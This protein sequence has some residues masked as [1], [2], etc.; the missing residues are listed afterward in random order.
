MTTPEHQLLKTLSPSPLTQRVCFTLT[1]NIRR[2]Q[3]KGK[4]TTNLGWQGNVFVSLVL[5]WSHLLTCKKKT[6]LRSLFCSLLYSLLLSAFLKL[7]IK[8]ICAWGICIFFQE[9]DNIWN[10]SPNIKNES[11]AVYQTMQLVWINIYFFVLCWGF[12]SCL[13][14]FRMTREK[15]PF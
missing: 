14:V 5:K 3:S 2:F 6:H 12:D 15:V 11:H 9:K 8:L 4:S 13:W 10:G 1:G 7:L